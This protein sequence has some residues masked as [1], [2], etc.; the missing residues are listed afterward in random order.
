LGQLAAARDEMGVDVLYMLL[1]PF[2]H[3]NEII[4]D[5]WAKDQIFCAIKQYIW[6]FCNIYQNYCAF[7]QLA[8]NKIE[9]TYIIDML[10]KFVS[11]AKE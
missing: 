3:I 5:A 6:A 7:M 1:V 8:H 11:K 10:L 2:Y 4:C 9:E